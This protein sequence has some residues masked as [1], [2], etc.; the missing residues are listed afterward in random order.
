MSVTSSETRR[1]FGKPPR[2]PREG[3]E[4][5]ALRRECGRYASVQPEQVSDGTGGRAGWRDRREVL[6]QQQQIRAWRVRYGQSAVNRVQCPRQQ[7]VQNEIRELG[8]VYGFA[9]AE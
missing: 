9:H 4:A 5:A 1:P 7:R 8:I 6:R 2:S 3:S